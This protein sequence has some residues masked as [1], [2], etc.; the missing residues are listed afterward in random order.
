MRPEVSFRFHEDL[1]VFI[2]KKHRNCTYQ[3]V[4]E[5]NSTIKDSVEVQGM[6]HTEIDWLLVNG[7]LANFAQTQKR[8][9]W[10][11]SQKR[12]RREANGRSSKQIQ[13]SIIDETLFYLSGL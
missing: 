1:N 5:E 8:R 12:R 4:F 10:V 11:F 2:E 9:I 7:G 3:Y 6:P 13:S